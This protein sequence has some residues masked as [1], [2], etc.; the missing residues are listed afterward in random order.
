MRVLIIVLAL[1]A[2]AAVAYGS[3]QLSLRADRKRCV[4]EAEQFCRE[5]AK[6]L[7]RRT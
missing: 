5:A 1:L 7:R 3:H 4:V 6:Q 2:I